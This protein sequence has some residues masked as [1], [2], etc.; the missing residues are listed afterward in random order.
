MHGT[1]NW[2]YGSPSALYR[3]RE[4]MTLPLFSQHLPT[5]QET[6]LMYYRQPFSTEY[7][8]IL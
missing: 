7:T 2:S 5:S 3:L 1:V 6:V 8:Q 4:D